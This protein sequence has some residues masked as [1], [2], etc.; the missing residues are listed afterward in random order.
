ML[1]TSEYTAQP[2]GGHEADR[3]FA[4]IDYLTARSSLPISWHSTAGVC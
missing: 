4:R 1:L 2:D 3:L